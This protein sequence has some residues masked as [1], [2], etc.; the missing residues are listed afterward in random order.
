M[1]RLSPPVAL[2]A[3]KKP[4]PLRFPPRAFGNSGLNLDLGLDAGKEGGSP[5]WSGLRSRGLQFRLPLFYLI[6]LSARSAIEYPHGPFP[7]DSHPEIDADS[8]PDQSISH[9]L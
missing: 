1:E 9:G 5:S 3:G 6:A 7:V 8:C 4:G 2:S